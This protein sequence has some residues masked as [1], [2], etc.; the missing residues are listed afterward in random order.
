MKES[1]YIIDALRYDAHSQYLRECDETDTRLAKIYR[2]DGRYS[3]VRAPSLDENRRLE[4]PDGSFT[5]IRDNFDTL[6]GELESFDIK[7]PEHSAFVSDIHTKDGKKGQGLCIV[8]EYIHGK[9]L[10]LEN[11]GL[12]NSNQE[13]FYDRMEQWLF[14]LTSYMASKYLCRECSEYFLTDVCR[15][16]QFVY[17]FDDSSIYLVDLDPLYEKIVDSGG[18]VNER[19]IVGIN[20]LNSLR[21]RYYNKGIA[22]GI[23]GKSWGKD[24]KKILEKMISDTDFVSRSRYSEGTRRIIKNLIQGIEYKKG[25]ID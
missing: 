25:R 21:N 16:I 10:P 9:C 3:V 13:L 17:S 24:S 7:V 1:E 23:T 2:G 4:Y 14:S 20:T 19:F 6:L 11:N 18:N 8:S 22:S 5:E 12:W 15:P